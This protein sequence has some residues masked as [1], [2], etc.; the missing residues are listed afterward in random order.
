MARTDAV[1]PRARGYDRP[2]AYAGKVLL[3]RHRSPAPPHIGGP[4]QGSGGCP[5]QDQPSSLVAWP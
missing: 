5:G 1:W 4:T 2:A 3:N